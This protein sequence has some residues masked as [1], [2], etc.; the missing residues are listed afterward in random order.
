MPIGA[1][2]SSAG[3]LTVTPDPRP[4]SDQADEREHARLSLAF[5]LGWAGVVALVLAVG[6]VV[7]VLAGG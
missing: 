1:R 7:W 2:R 4:E 6:I 3:R 5:F